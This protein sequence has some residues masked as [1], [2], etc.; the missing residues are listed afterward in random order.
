LYASE[1]IGFG[2]EELL[3]LFLA[4]VLR[5]PGLVEGLEKHGARKVSRTPLI[6]AGRT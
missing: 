5:D 2:G 1:S 3:D 6:L 4:K